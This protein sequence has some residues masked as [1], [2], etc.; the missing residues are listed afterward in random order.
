MELFSENPEEFVHKCVIPK[1]TVPD[2]SR[3]QMSVCH[4]KAIGKNRYLQNTQVGH[5]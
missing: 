4:G 1:S 2:K 5:F 3:P